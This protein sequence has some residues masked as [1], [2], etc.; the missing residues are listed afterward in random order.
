MP[1]I[2]TKK[3]SLFLAAAATLPVPP[4]GF[5]ETTEAVLPNI[6][7]SSIDINRVTGHLNTKDSVVDTCRSKV[8]F[9]AKMNMRSNDVGATALDTVP[10]VG[11]LLRCGGFD[12][13]VDTGTPSEE[14]VTYTN[15]K[16]AINPCS[17]VIFV[18]GNKLEATNSLVSETTIDIKIGEP[19]TVTGSFSGFIDDV[20][21]TV[22]ANPTTTLTQEPLLIS[23]CAD[24][25]LFDGSCIPIESAVI[26]MNTETAE[27]YTFGG[28][29]C[30]LKSNVITD[31]AI[32]LDL[33]FYV[34][35]ANYGREAA[36]IESGQA[37][38][39]V[40]K[41]GLDDTG[42]LVNGKSVEITCDLAKSTNY[43]D[44]S[45]NDLLSRTLNLR[46]FDGVNSALAIKFGF[47]N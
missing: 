38:A 43:S 42:A 1:I 17:A 40:F 15:N 8:S 5:I 37:K 3:T 23:S 14:T 31:Y 26:K 18:D 47:F 20:S 46:L 9:D 36:L 13:V 28:N 27:L 7:F 4:V 24:L 19:A 30:G 29:S 12:E 33:T 34:D 45:N 25:V 11:L 22:E 21:G 6:E 35:K 16:D 10:E 44:S 32:T 41:L 2:S 39:V